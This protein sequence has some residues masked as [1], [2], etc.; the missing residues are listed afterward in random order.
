MLSRWNI[1]ALLLD[2]LNSEHYRDYM[3][4]KCTICKIFCMKKCVNLFGSITFNTWSVNPLEYYLISLRWVT[5]NLLQMIY[6][7]LCVRIA[8]SD[9]KTDAWNWQKSSIFLNRDKWKLGQDLAVYFIFTTTRERL[10]KNP[11]KP[12]FSN[13]QHFS[14]KTFLDNNH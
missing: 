3:C 4:E 14:S 2:Q 1:R 9:F 5:Y 7:H 6:H 11:I 12:N 13:R 10:N 8:T